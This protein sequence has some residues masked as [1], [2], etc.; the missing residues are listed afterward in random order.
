MDNR[1]TV[2]TDSLLSSAHTLK[3]PWLLLLVTVGIRNDY[4]SNHATQIEWLVIASVSIVILNTM[5]V[6]HCLNFMV[7][8]ML[9]KSY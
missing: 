6:N 8:S 2:M 7:S 9:R 4:R 1:T 5:E 3:M